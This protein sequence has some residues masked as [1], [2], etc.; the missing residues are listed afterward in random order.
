MKTYYKQYSIFTF[1]N[2]DYL[3]EPYLVQKNDWLYKI[4][5]QKG[6]ISASDFPRFLKIFKKI[7]PKL[8]NIDAI[9]P[10]HQ[11]LIPLKRVKGQA[12]Q[13]KETGIVEVPVLE[14]SLEFE[15]EKLADFIRQHTIRTG[16]TVSTLLGKE[17]LKKGGAVSDVGE[18]T[19]TLLNPDITDINQIY[20]GTQVLVPSPEILSQPWFDTF[21][22]QGIPQKDKQAG[23]Q[24]GVKG[25]TFR[26]MP[27]PVLTPR[28]L[29][30]L[31]RYARLIEGT[32]M[33][34]GKM[35]FPGKDGT[36]AKELD[37]SK[38]PLLK[39]TDGS[40]TLILPPDTPAA[41][42]DQDLLRAM[43]AYWREIRLQE[44]N[45]ALSRSPLFNKPRLS[46]DEMPESQ[47]DLIKRLMSVTPYTYTP[48]ENIPVVQDKIRM[49][50][51]MGRITHPREPDRLINNGNV[52]GQALDTIKTQGYE[53]LTLS[54]ELSMG[55][56][57]LLLFSHLGYD[58]WKN[59]AINENGKV[60]TLYGLYVSRET[61][62]YFVVRTL[63]AERTRDFLTR[64]GIELL[65][66]EKT[67]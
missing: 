63:P 24:E 20:L 44:L 54:P 11:I 50:V 53:V 55:E 2:E 51:I 29:S 61:E 58:T 7:N 10:G 13:Q 31:K 57:S 26:A 33:H 5:R 67:P 23:T 37:L 46:L 66:I 6:E 42:F 49:T 38:T 27:Q 14:F 47:D 48:D 40:K 39:E 65:T 15:K 60:E 59:P 34:Q 4:F 18:K 25:K 9:A 8:S 64:E 56:I 36:P 32:L 12:Y 3:C 17:F 21:L 16:D 35:Y 28:D 52:Y 45:K 62:K 30:R 22:A 43:K 1:Q 41:D 19:F